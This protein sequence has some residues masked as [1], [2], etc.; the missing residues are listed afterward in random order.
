MMSRLLTVLVLTCAAV[1]R[2]VAADLTP[3]DAFL[4]TAS[5][6]LDQLKLVQAQCGADLTTPAGE[7]WCL[8]KADGGHYAYRMDATGALQIMSAG[9]FTDLG[10]FQDWGVCL[11]TSGDPVLWCNYGQDGHFVGKATVNAQ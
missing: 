6:V 9:H 8:S 7:Y 4:A 11:K 3:E 10:Y 1:S 2:A 5:K